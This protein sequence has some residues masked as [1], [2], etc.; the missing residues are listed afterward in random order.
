MDTQNPKS[1]IQNLLVIGG[2]GYVGN[3]VLP[4]L[5]NHFNLRIFD[6]NPP[7]WAE[8]LNSQPSTLNYVP[9]DLTNGPALLAAAQNMDLLLYM[10]MGRVGE[11]DIDNVTA[12]YDVNV[13]GVHLA[14]D[15]AV[16]AGIKRAVY[17]SSL[18]VYDGQL[19][20][21][22]GAT[23][24]EDILPRSRKVYGFTKWLGE[25]VCAYF[26]RTHNLPIVALRLFHPVPDSEKS[27]PNSDPSDQ[28]D[29]SDRSD[30]QS[31]DGRTAASDLA[32]ALTAA[33]L[34]EHEGFEPIHITGDTSG[35]AYKHEK[36][37]RLLDWQPREI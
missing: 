1:K 35:Q 7:A 9:G 18:S 12:A 27:P 2:S 14:L 28:S 6:R 37:K 15:A 24:R 21:R 13:K 4:T 36:A 34:L 19:D 25:E 32:R 10:A 17:T 29:M 11:R 30:K 22:S 5:A 26:S 20:I 23:D 33:L 16:K 3:L 8:T 31:P